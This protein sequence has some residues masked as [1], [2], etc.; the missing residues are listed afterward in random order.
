M[1]ARLFLGNCLTSYKNEYGT[2]FV[3]PCHPDYGII[4]EVEI[5]QGRFLNNIDISEF[6][7][8]A[9]IGEKVKSDLFK[10]NDNNRVYLQLPAVLHI[11]D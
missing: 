6:R 1:S 8:V 10:G 5:L 2:F 7:K 3:S 4:K 11:S 9:V